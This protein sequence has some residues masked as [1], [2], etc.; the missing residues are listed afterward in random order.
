MRNIQIGKKSR[1]LPSVALYSLL[2]LLT[3]LISVLSFQVG[4]AMSSMFPAALYSVL[5]LLTPQSPRWLVSRGLSHEARSC[6]QKL[7]KLD[8][9]INREVVN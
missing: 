6:L 1:D 7:R 4:Q 2:E 8:Y 5:A 3:P 9:N